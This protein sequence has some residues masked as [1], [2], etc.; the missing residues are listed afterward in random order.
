[1]KFVGLF[2]SGVG[3]LTVAKELLGRY[4]QVN[5]AYL[6]DTIHM[7]YGVRTGDDIKELTA[8]NIVHLGQT[9]ELA[10]VVIACNTAT[11]YGLE[12]TQARMDVPVVGM[13]GPTGAYIA[14]NEAISKVLVVAT[15]GTVKS[16]AYD[17]AV[18][19]AAPDTEVRGIGT[20]KLVLAIEEGRTNDEVVR[21]IIREALEA[22]P[23]Y[24]FDAV[25]MGCTHFPIAKQ[26]FVDVLEEIGS[27]AELIDPAVYAV[28]E[29]LEK[30][31]QVPEAG[32]EKFYTTGDVDE[33]SAAVDTILEFDAAHRHHVG[34][35]A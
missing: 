4:P 22:Y 19:A 31:A 30:I 14:G 27:G 16:G 21:G 2:D 10:G 11:C 32:E 7:P 28:N 35:L 33:F 12:E 5:I 1:M 6:G 15:E 26:A 25:V 23:G 20:P 13:V 8:G 9:D 24:D 29:L 3:G 17:A 34:K 18:H